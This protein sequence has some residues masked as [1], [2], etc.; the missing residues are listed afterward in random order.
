MSLVFANNIV[1]SK[2]ELFVRKLRY[3]FG[4]IMDPPAPGYHHCKWTATKPNKPIIF[5]AQDGQFLDQFNK[6]LNQKHSKLDQAVQHLA[7]KK[8]YPSTLKS[9]KDELIKTAT[10]LRMNNYDEQSEKIHLAAEGIDIEELKK[11]VTIVFE[12]SPVKRPSDMIP[13]FE[14][15]D[16]IEKV[17]VD[18]DFWST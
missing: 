2:G 14:M 15:V 8:G 18:I 9:F 6:E 16:K 13:L 11:C 12:N 7:T 3:H 10:E 5:S 1:R 17:S 4:P